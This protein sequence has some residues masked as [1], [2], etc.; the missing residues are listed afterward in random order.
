MAK[1]QQLSIHDEYFELTEKYSSIY[2]ENTILLMQVGAFFEVYGGHSIMK[3]KIEEFSQI[4]SLNVSEKMKTKDNENITMAGFRDY[5]LEKYVL[6]LTENGYNAVVYVQAKRPDD[7]IDRVFSCVYSPGTYISYDTDTSKQITNNIMCIWLEKTASAK[8]TNSIIIGISSINIFTGKSKIFE[9]QVPLYMN[10]TTFDEIER[11]ISIIA[12][13]EVI[14]ISNFNSQDTDKIIQYSGIKCTSI[15]IL[16]TLDPELS[17]YKK[18]KIENCNKQTYIK[19]MLSNVFGCEAYEVC[20]EFNQSE[21]S[22]QSF[23]Y[24]LDFIQEHN[25]DLIK[26]ITIPEFYNVSTEM[27]LA[28][29]TLKQLNVI[30]DVS[31]DGN[32]AGNLSSVIAFLNKCQSAIGKR[33]LYNEIT[34]PKFDIQWLNK[35]YE[36]IDLFEKQIEIDVLQTLRQQLGCIYDIE[37]ICRQI[38]VGKI[39]PSSIHNLYKSIFI[40]HQINTILIENTKISEYLSANFKKITK[41]TNSIETICN[42]IMGMMDSKLNIENCKGQTSISDFNKNIIRP[43]INSKL[44]SIVQKY[45]NNIEKYNFIY[46]YFNEVCNKSSNTQNVE[47]IKKHETDKSG[48]SL[49]ITKKRSEILKR[50]LDKTAVII[51]GKRTIKMGEIVAEDDIKYVH[52]S[53]ANNTIS[54]GALS[55]ITQELVQIED[56]LNIITKEEFMNFIKT[57]ELEWLEYIQVIS[58]YIARLDVITCKSWIA[59]KFNYCKPSID[60]TAEKSFVDAKKLRHVLIEHLQKNEIYVANDI[61][62]GKDNT[63]GILLYGTNAVGKTSIIKALGISIIMAQSGMY[64]P[65][66]SFTYH[67]YKSIY[68]RILGNDNIFKGLSTFAVEM[69]ELRIILKM[70]DESSLILGDELCSGTETESALSIFTA[71]LMTLHEKKSSF[72]FATHFHEIL[73]Y[74]EIQTLSNLALRHMSVHYDR[75]LDCLVYDRI[76]KEG[77]GNMTYGLEVCKSLYLDEEFLELAYNI[78]SKYGKC[79]GGLSDTQSASYN[80]DKIRGKCEMCNE[81]M[82]EEIHH[83]SPQCDSDENGFIDTF[84]KNHPANLASVC[85]KCHDKIHACEKSSPPKKEKKITQRKKTTKGYVL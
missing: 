18:E 46:E 76:I 55:R 38:V 84:H 13:S 78:R 23:C 73:K 70:S 77:A 42:N 64:V 56:E 83:L 41:S 31:N 16:L 25:P 54:F 2:G 59:R 43:N 11:H 36:M 72:I 15:H 65:C 7:K 6:K 81:S 44:D 47:Y 82:G 71:G 26:K 58:E 3:S 66:S 5:C 28:N 39:M 20:K 80:S 61:S 22:T 17:K 33:Q 45:N 53:G 9:Y 29:H 79:T 50:E 60:A 14:I 69:S 67:P 52:A 57:I 48:L 75:E 1:Q 49:Q 10:P 34:K 63:D 62:I 37:K 68:T 40:V 19:H 35:E 4:C 30:D 21:I 8:K 51:N 12:P 32:R 27:V 24:L 85:S 74:D